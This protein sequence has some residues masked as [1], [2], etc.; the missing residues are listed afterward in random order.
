M[1][2]RLLSIPDFEEALSRAYASAVAAGAGYLTYNPADFDRDS[3]DIGFSAGGQMRPHLHAQL[4]ATVDLRKADV[5][6]RYKIKKKN[7]D[8]LR[9]ATAVPR[10]IVV[11]S[12]P[13][14][15]KKWLDISVARLIMRRC[16]F[17]ATLAGE[18]DLPDGQQSKT[19]KISQ[20]N[21]FDVDGLRQLMDMARVGKIK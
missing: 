9:V 19:I 1:S 21:R 7:Y 6:Y 17:W 2:D 11:L 13:R 12:L 18:P 3:V 14:D 5:S 15:Q 4:K 8:D 16:A 10:I 20:A